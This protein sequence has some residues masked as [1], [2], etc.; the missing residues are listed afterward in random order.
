MKKMNLKTKIPSYIVLLFFFL[1]WLSPIYIAVVKSFSINGIANY[2]YVLNHPKINYF[3][4]V[5][6]SLFMSIGT[7]AIIVVITTLASF[8]FSK[9]DFRGK[10]TIYYMILACLAIPIAAVTV[11]L[12][13]T[14]NKL[15]F[16]DTWQGVILP[17]VAFNAP[18]MLLMV[19]N[20]FDGIPNELLE[21]AKIDGYNSFQTYR[22]IM[23]PLSVP[24]I[25]TVGVLTFVYSW[26]EY[27]IPL[28]MIRSESKYTITLA[29]RYFMET[30]HQ[31]PA[32]VARVYSALILMTIPSVVIYLF[33][34]KYLQS[35]IT[36]G[37]IKS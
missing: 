30:T 17:L 11:P 21:A 23:L 26:N 14:M 10:K 22:I 9:M 2:T 33:S 29:S 28:L 7:A 12:F 1:L 4:V 27:L 20:Y 31:S 5:S 35:G 37:A 34:Q 19:K 15:R 36:A 24:I 8:A 6:N 16:V 18:L 3:R 32:D 13:F 25:A